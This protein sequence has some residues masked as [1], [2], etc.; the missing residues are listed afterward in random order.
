VLAHPRSADAMLQLGS[1][2][3]AAGDA[4]AAD[5]SFQAA[6]RAAPDR[7]EPKTL[8]AMVVAA[9]GHAAAA[10]A[11][12]REV[13]RTHPRYAR[14]WLLDGLLEAHNRRTYPRA[15]ADWQRFLSLQPHGPLA[16]D[17]RGWIRSLR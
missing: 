2:Y 1:D 14:A 8:H 13:E 12:L 15:I 3:L 6:M 5:R 4:V 7:P 9:A 10:H 17:V 16:R 11:L